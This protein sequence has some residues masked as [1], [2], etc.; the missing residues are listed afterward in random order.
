ME[1]FKSIVKTIVGFILLAKQWV[2]EK[3]SETF[4]FYEKHKAVRRIFWIWAVLNLVFRPDLFL[5]YAMVLTALCAIIRAASKKE[6][7]EDSDK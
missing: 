5:G 2:D 1:K 7:G 6:K 3:L 4:T